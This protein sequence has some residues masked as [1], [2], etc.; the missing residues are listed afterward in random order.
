MTKAISRF[1]LVFMLAL[2]GISVTGD[3]LAVVKTKAISYKDGNLALRGT[4]AWDDAIKGKRP[5]VLIVHEWWGLDDY[6]KGRA[7]Q[8][9]AAG[10]VT[11][12]LDMYGA[13][14]ITK[15]ADQAGKWAK[16]VN[17]NIEGWVRRAQSG[18]S[19]L[20]ADGNVDGFRTAAIRYCFG[21]PT[22]MQMAYAGLGR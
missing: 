18:L 9:A 19:V 7:K 11:F 15:H 4:I 16:Q 12:A 2:V 14:K 5:G 6:A 13:D 8:L 10:Y 21:D 3:A 17:S 20:K 1:M 22:V